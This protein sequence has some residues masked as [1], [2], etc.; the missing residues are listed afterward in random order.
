M[1]VPTGSRP[2][3][4]HPAAGAVTAA[5]RAAG[6]VFAED[7]AAL[8]LDTAAGAAEVDEMVRRRTAGHPLE[9]VLGWAAFCGSRIAVDAGVFV[10]RR[11]TEFLVRLAIGLGRARPA[12]GAAAADQGGS[13]TAEASAVAPLLVVDLCC[14]SGALG[15]AV[16]AA[17]GRVRL[18]AADC[19]PA[20]VRCARRNVGP[21][22]GT[23]HEGDLYDAL[24][25]ALRGQVDLLIANVPY[26]PTAEIGL[27]PAEA[28]E[29]EPRVAL[30]G[31]TDG[32]EVLRRVAAQ[33]AS[34]LAPGGSLL[35]E[36]SDRQAATA[37]A[38]LARG[39]LAARIEADPDGGATALVGT[40]RTAGLGPVHA[41]IKRL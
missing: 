9:H 41:K 35:V 28:R 4:A 1:P 32:L 36:T 22:G 26:V 5:L 40:R 17:L 3:A 6:C 14:G 39:G 10:P 8:I 7:E 13:A 25:A 24:P 27:L 31:G 16:S 11:R 20:A 37:A 29:H 2:A 19:D 15:L 34:W 12:P 23:V 18:H 30:D 33:A 38:I 21:A